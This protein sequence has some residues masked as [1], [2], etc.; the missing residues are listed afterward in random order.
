MADAPYIFI[1]YRRSTSASYPAHSITR[2]LKSQYGRSQ[3]FVDV[4]AILVGEDFLER[5]Y[6]ELDRCDVLL[7]FIGPYWTRSPDGRYDINNEND[8]VR[9][10]IGRAFQQNI[11]ILPFLVDGASMPCA[12]ELPAEI[13]K[14]TLI[15][16][17][18]LPADRIGRDLPEIIDDIDR[19]WAGGSAKRGQASSADEEQAS[20][21]DRSSSRD[22]RG[23][24]SSTRS[25]SREDAQTRE[26]AAGV[27]QLQDRWDWKA[28]ADRAS[29]APGGETASP[30][31][32]RDALDGGD[33][34]PEMVIIPAGSFRMGSP[35]DEPD[36][37]EDEGPQRLVTIASPFAMARYAVTFEEYDRFAAA[38]S[39][40]PPLDE[41]WGRGRQPVIYVSWQDAVSYTEWL[42]AETGRNYRLPSE[43]EWEYATRA[44]T[45]TPYWW[46]AEAG[47]NQANF[48]GSGS[49]WS[50]RQTAPV[51]AFS[52]NP[53]GLFQM[54]GNV[55]EWIEDTWHTSYAEA[56]TDGAAWLSGSPHVRML[57]G[58][59]CLSPRSDVRSACRHH[60][61][62][63][64]RLGLIGFRV[65]CS[66]DES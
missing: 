27:G 58:G 20:A 53:F 51:D 55:W 3:V 66:L 34:G 65:A 5:I 40:L 35:E 63:S 18:L 14:L 11:P 2:D 39:R 43:A 44:G 23:R 61:V 17:R 19:M 37:E 24:S 9:L 50:G 47:T 48:D 38:T 60:A 31:G 8:F 30:A 15:N 21:G 49:S 12:A 52:P 46:G 45:T 13:S 62:T 28:H 56:P 36:R 7:V 29:D 1:S 42:R 10:E 64:G 33:H 59:M 41:G 22:P 32:F 6:R 57:R 4:D 16:A 26:V 25:R 54:A